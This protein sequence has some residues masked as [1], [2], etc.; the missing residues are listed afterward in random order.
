MADRLISYLFTFLLIL[1][2]VV[3]ASTDDQVRL[4]TA[5]VL[6]GVIV[7]L[8]LLFNWLSTDG[9]G[10]AIVIGT[11]SYGLGGWTGAFAILFF[12]IG[13]HLLTLLLFR[14]KNLEIL[15]QRYSERRDGTQVWSNGFVFTLFLFLWF[16]FELDWFMFIALGA[17]AVALADTWAS[18][19][20]ERLKGVTTRLITNF[21]KVDAGTDGG[22]SLAGT[23]AALAGTTLFSIGALYVFGQLS[24]W[25][26]IIAVAAGGFLGC[27][28]DSYLGAICQYGGRHL[29]IP[30]GESKKLSNNGVNAA[31][32]IIG[33]LTTLIILII[34]EYALV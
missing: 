27:I 28:A 17:L 11:A 13:T 2:Y 32:T 6:S 4:S 21:K 9:A 26:A 20:G 33:A 25:Q 29:W 14:K 16:Y 7:I 5:L 1:F 23:F 12:F 10:S 22:V 15:E 24:N 18:E 19:T 34:F 3:F 30:F 31:A 8:A